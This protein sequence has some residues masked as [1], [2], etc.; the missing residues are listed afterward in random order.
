MK[1][2]NNTLSCGTQGNCWIRLCLNKEP[3]LLYNKCVCVNVSS[4][5]T[6]WSHKIRPSRQH[7]F[8]AMH[9]PMNS[10]RTDNK[11]LIPLS[12]FRH[13]AWPHTFFTSLPLCEHFPLRILRGVYSFVC[14]L[15]GCVSNN[16]VVHDRRWHFLLMVTLVQDG[17][18]ERAR[19]KEN[20]REGG[21]RGSSADTNTPNTGGRHT[22]LP[23]R[24]V[25]WKCFGSE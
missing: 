3:A 7:L 6:G 24:T 10:L 5:H 19:G 13:Y 25:K 8:K 1:W 14:V 17:P 11:R 9:H 15:C 18:C 12:L 22:L 21:E 2:K 4:Q 20:W 23:Q 16:V